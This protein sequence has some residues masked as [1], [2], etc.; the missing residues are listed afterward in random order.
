MQELFTQAGLELPSA[1]LVLRT[2]VRLLTAVLLAALV[3]WERGVHG[4]AAGLRTHMMVALGAALFT[5]VPINSAGAQA[6][7]TRIVQGIAAGVGFLGA[8]AILKMT[9]EKDILGL[10]T[11]SSI[12]LT[13]AI[14]LAAGAGQ[15]STAFF[16]TIFA[17][18]ILI[19]LRRVERIAIDPQRSDAKTEQKS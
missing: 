11:A 1:T 9:T 15:L 14:G 5:I 8:G 7:I 18:V 2:S 16:A 17:L 13:A 12:W 10:T 6:D 3:G 19:Y 4:R